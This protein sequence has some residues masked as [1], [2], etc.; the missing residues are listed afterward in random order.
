MTQSEIHTLAMTGEI[1]RLYGHWWQ[2]STPQIM[3]PTHPPKFPP[4]QRTCRLC[5]RTEVK[6]PETWEA[7][8]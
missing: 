6:K 7:R 5:G 4:F 2:D 3:Y 8:E 1:C